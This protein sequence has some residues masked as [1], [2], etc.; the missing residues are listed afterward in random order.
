MEPNRFSQVRRSARGETMN[1][2]SACS[3]HANYCRN[4][5]SLTP[6]DR[7]KAYWDELADSWFALHNA[8]LEREKD[9]NARV[10][11]PR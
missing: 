6:D 9:I 3:A 8:A 5:A 7:L 10:L 2:T 1:E 11:Q 4:Q